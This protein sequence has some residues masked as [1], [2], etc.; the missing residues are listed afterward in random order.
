MTHANTPRTFTLFALGLAMILW[1]VGPASAATRSVCASGC[2]Y[3]SIQAAID[4]SSN[5]DIVELDPET[6]TEG[7]IFVDVDVTIRTSSGRATVDADGDDYVFKI[8]L[9]D[10]LFEDL[11]LEGAARAM[12]LNHGDAELST[13]YVLG[14]STDTSYGGIFNG[15]SA[16]LTLTDAS[17]VAANSSSDHPG[18]I[19]NYGDLVINNSTITGN[20]G[21]RGGGVGN[22]GGTVTV[23]SS[24]FSFNNS[25]LRGGAWYNSSSGSFTFASSS[26]Y[27][28]NTSDG[29]CDKY[30]DRSVPECID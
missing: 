2:S 9:A 22:M 25:E 15:V 11:T 5:G 16:S 4:A 8:W 1:L 24:S 13:V 14:D 28:G 7:D 10:V 12:L 27:S 19:T 17:L 30:D 21:Y 6:F 26:S 20:Q 23:T 3:T 18:G 29:D